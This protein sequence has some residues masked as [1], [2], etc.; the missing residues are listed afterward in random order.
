MSQVAA[1]LLCLMLPVLALAQ[2]AG[3]EAGDPVDPEQRAAQAK[4]AFD[5]AWDLMQAR[6]YERACK[7][8]ERSQR[9]D[10]GMG[11]QFRLAECYDKAGRIASAWRNYVE[12]ARLA[13]KVGMVK[14]E[15]FA[16]QR[17]EVLRPRLI[18][19]TIEIPEAVAGIGGLEI[20][21]NGE[22]VTRPNWGQRAPV[23]PGALYV[24]ANAPGHVR[25]TKRLE[26]TEEGEAVTVHVPFLDETP[27]PY[28]V[29]DAG[30]EAGAEATRSSGTAQTA[31]GIAVT[32]A[33]VADMIVGT[34]LALVAKSD[35]DESGPYCDE[36]YCDP[37]GVIIR[38]DARD[39][40][41]AATVVFV[42]GAVATAGGVVIWLTAPSDD[43]EPEDAQARAPHPHARLGIA[44]TL[45]GL[46]VVAGARW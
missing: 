32:G 12:V 39:L 22:L 34:V 8:F 24:V 36:T 19:L 10:P 6:A 17:A 4:K 21:R 26:L 9:L 38:D 35:W 3:A 2:P 44:P 5:Q 20:R 27:T 42:V 37:E 25:W 31:A 33:G 16:S 40:G 13:H 14:R 23:D 29:P 41:T 11:T 1:L 7:L 43:G 46:Q 30:Q 18:E 45:G 28:D 15:R